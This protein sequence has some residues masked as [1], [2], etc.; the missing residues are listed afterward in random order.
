MRLAPATF[1]T[2]KLCPHTGSVHWQEIAGRLRA[3]PPR[4]LAGAADHAIA[5]IE[6]ASGQVRVD[7]LAQQLGVRQILFWEGDYIDA[8]ANKESLQAW[9]R[10]HA[11]ALAPAG[12]P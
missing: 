12:R 5:A 7:G 11:Q 6:A 2:A 9:M 1:R 3:A 8:R 10:A 4:R